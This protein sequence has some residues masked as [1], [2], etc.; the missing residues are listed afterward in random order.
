MYKHFREQVFGWRDIQDWSIGY[1]V[2]LL[3]SIFFMTM[4]VMYVMYFKQ[5]HQRYQFAQQQQ[6]QQRQQLAQ[7]NVWVQQVDQYQQQYQQQRQMFTPLI[8]VDHTQVATIFAQMTRLS[9]QHSSPIIQLRQQH[10]DPWSMVFEVQTT[11]QSF[12]QLVQALNQ[13]PYALQMTQ[14]TLVRSQAV[15]DSKYLRG[16]MVLKAYVYE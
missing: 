16:K 13:L 15:T 7:A 8:P 12:L 2:G 11:F 5:F 1:I 9:K 3:F 4:G 10:S 14:M 6:Q